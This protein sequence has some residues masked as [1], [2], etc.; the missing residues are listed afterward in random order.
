M[1]QS[2]ERMS[3]HADTEQRRGERTGEGMW[4]NYERSPR[5]FAGAIQIGRPEVPNAMDR[6]SFRELFQFC[7]RTIYFTFCVHCSVDSTCNRLAA[8]A[9]AYNG[10]NAVAR[11]YTVL[12]TP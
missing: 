11:S 8:C 12:Y 9:S 2:P 10:T 4:E 5:V 1:G 6:V 7:P 3:T